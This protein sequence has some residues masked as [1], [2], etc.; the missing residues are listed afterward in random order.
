MQGF[1]NIDD[2]KKYDQSLYDCESLHICENRDKKLKFRIKS[3]RG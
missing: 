2:F 1:W 3:Q